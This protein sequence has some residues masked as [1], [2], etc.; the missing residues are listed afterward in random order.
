MVVYYF[1]PIGGPAR[2]VITRITVCA[3]REGA[4]EKD[5]RIKRHATAPATPARPVTR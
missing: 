5:V 2:P 3:R 1:V 4:Y